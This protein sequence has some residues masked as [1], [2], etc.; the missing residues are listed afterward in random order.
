[1]NGATPSAL[2]RAG[3]CTIPEGRGVF[4]NLTVRENLWMMTYRGTSLARVEEVAYRYF[5]R[6]AE[7]RDQ[8][9]GTMSGGEQQML[10]VARAVST[11]P[12]LLLLDEL[13]MGLAPIIVESL[14]EAVGRLA[15]DGVSILVV[16]QFAETV[17]ALADHAVV[18]SQGR[19]AVEG[20]PAAIRSELHAA[21][22]GPG[23]GTDRAE[24]DPEEPDPQETDR[25]MT[26]RTEAGRGETGRGA[27]GKGPANRHTSAQDGQGGD[28]TPEETST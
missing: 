24:P 18:V 11:E 1:M 12:A 6:L 10:A 27:G 15:A 9:A 22:L 5:P 2:A 8:V 21:Y 28:Q 3:L 7:R 4:P 17:L 26:T 19:V 20:T 23:V 13:S 14:Y 25:A 16:E